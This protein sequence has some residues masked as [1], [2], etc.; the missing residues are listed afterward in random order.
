MCY[1]IFFTHILL[2][3]HLSEITPPFSAHINDVKVFVGYI[4]ME[5]EIRRDP[6]VRLDN[7]LPTIILEATSNGH[8][9]NSKRVSS[10]TTIPKAYCRTTFMTSNHS[11]P[12]PSY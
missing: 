4:F 3:L 7:G 1:L 9:F 5:D 12:G 8:S 2:D 6:A 11:L 10:K